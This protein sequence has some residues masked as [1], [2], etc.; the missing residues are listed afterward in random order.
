[1]TNVHSQH[2]KTFSQQTMC[3]GCHNQDIFR[4]L[5]KNHHDWSE[6]KDHQVRNRCNVGLGERFGVIR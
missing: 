6:G 1:M 2:L 4:G 3:H 5:R